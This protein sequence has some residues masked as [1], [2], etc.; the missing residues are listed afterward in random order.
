MTKR[1]APRSRSRRVAPV[2]APSHNTPAYGELVGAVSGLG[3]LVATFLPFYSDGEANATAWQAFSV[4]DLVMGAAA[5]VGLSV[6]LVVLFRL[7]VSYPVAGS[8][9]TTLLGGIALL[10]VA[11]RMVNPPGGGGELDL[12]IGAWLG[13]LFAAGVT[14]GGYLGMQEPSGRRVPSAG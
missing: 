8:A 11:Y 12:R 4:V 10:L 2:G 3:L 9:V 6:G 7:S 1:V 5:I 14:V 13:L